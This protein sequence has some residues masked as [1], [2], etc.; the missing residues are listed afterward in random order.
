MP[1]FLQALNG[2]L[3]QCR[4]RD[5]ALDWR[6]MLH[7]PYPLE[8]PKGLV[9][10]NSNLNPILFH[11]KYYFLGVFVFLIITTGSANVEVQWEVCL[12]EVCWHHFLKIV[13]IFS[14]F[15]F[16]SYVMTLFLWRHNLREKKFTK[17]HYGQEPVGAE[18]KLLN[19][20]VTEN[21]QAFNSTLKAF[22]FPS[23]N[24]EIGHKYWAKK[25][26]LFPL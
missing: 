5:M 11:Q 15:T 18:R 12:C 26:Y 14:S 23:C 19:W 6:I 22:T 20:S 1:K 10:F 8:K 21:R 2:E 13:W 25:V 4:C 16:L 7:F 24:K 9:F 17:W 3:K